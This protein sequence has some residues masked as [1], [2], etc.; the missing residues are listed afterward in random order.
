MARFHV[1]EVVRHLRYRY[2]GVIVGADPTCEAKDEWY[3]G[4]QTQPDQ[5]QPWY[6]VL[7]HGGA[8]HYVAEEN[9]ELDPSGAE[10]DHPYVPRVFASFHKGRYY[11]ESLN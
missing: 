9:L 6:Q 10:V 2:R 7:R 4:N 11:R 3:Q 8:E 1:G 5:N